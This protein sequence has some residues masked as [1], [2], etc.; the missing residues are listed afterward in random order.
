[1]SAAQIFLR[2]K[3]RQRALNMERSKL[4]CAME[5]ISIKQRVINDLT[6]QDNNRDLLLWLHFAFAR[7]NETQKTGL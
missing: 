1:M 5:R 4:R 6:S 2:D 3:R 7:L